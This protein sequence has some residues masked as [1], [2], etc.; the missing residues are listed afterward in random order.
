[1]R[2]QAIPPYQ[3][4]NKILLWYLGSMFLSYRITEGHLILASLC[5]KVRADS[6]KKN[7]LD[8]LNAIVLHE[9]E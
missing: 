6:K 4:Q 8:G 1:M 3:E 2:L 7:Q 5:P 9:D